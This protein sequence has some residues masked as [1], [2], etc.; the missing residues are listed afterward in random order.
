[1]TLKKIYRMFYRD[2][3]SA[4]NPVKYARKVGVNLRGYTYMGR[5]HGE[6]NRG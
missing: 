5:L 2:I 3:W 1:M 4:R 6:L